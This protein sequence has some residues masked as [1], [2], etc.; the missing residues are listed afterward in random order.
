MARARECQVVRPGVLG[1]GNGVGQDSK[2][3]QEQPGGG[4]SR[5]GVGLCKAKA[6]KVECAS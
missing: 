1:R 3:V 5:T 2:E 6:L 4:L